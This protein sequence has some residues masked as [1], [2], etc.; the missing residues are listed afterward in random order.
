MLRNII[1]GLVVLAAAVV[2]GAYLLPQNA[3]VERA[4]VFKAAPDEIFTIVNDLTRF[5]EWS[6]WA[7]LD[8]N[9]K[10]TLDPLRP[11]S[12]KGAKMSWTSEDPNV[13]NGS[14]EIVE[15]EPF[16]LIKMKLDFGSDGIAYGTFTF[17]PVEGGTR[18]VWAFDSDLG[19]SPVSRYFGL[20]FDS[21]IGKDYETG[22]ARLKELAESQ[23]NASTQAALDAP[24]GGQ[25]PD[26]GMPAADPTKGPEIITVEARP[27][28]LTRASAKAND[29]AAI[30]VALGAAYQKVLTYAEANGLEVGGL[31][32]AITISHSADADWVFDAA[33]PLNGEPSAAPAE[34]DGVK[35]GKTYAGRVVK[36]THKGAYSTLN[37]SYDRLHAF[38]K[39][40]NL[41][42]KATSWE[43][44]VSDPGET[45]D[46]DLLT[47][48]YLAVE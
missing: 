41:K 40:N 24:S 46:Q 34:A 7:K 4:M 35:I 30:S 16:K 6:P 17:E 37:T 33:M 36:V 47:N 39:A 23:A 21:M 14:Q 38:A 3:H 22:L 10:Y 25:P 26:M 48:I 31:P 9:A 15:S 29:N 12:G 8:A 13:G 27:A 32:L 5:N 1:I 2:G 43:E 11:P 45:Q 19:M 18:V 42:E 28:L 20:M 44:Y